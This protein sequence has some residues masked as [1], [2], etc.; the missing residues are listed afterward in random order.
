MSAVIRISSLMEQSGVAFGTSGARG[1]ETA[2]TDEVCYAYTAAFIQMLETRGEIPGENA[3]VALAGDLRPSTPRIMAAVARAVADRG[4]AVINCGRVPSPAVALHGL[5]QG[6]PS[7]MVTGSH[8]PQDRNGIKFNKTTGEILKPDEME[9]KA[10]QVILPD[11]FDGNGMFRSAWSPGPEQ[12]DAEEAY[13]NRWIKGFP[14]NCLKGLR[15]G[16][17]GHSAVG[18]ELLE[19]ITTELGAHVTRLG[20]SETFIAVDTEAIRPEDVDLALRW[21]REGSFDAIVSTDGDGDRPLISDENGK[22]IRGDV[23]GILC[24]SFLGADTVVT[25]VS[26]NTAVEKLGAFEEVRRT[27]I[28]SPYVIEGMMEAVTAGRNRV[29]GYE[30]NGGFLTASPIPID[31]GGVLDPLPTRD[32][33]VV[34]LGLLCL[35]RRKGISLSRLVAELPPRFTASDRLKDFPT[36]M[37]LQIVA[38][39][40]K[41]GAGA[42]ERA[43][44]G[45]GRVTSVNDLDGLRMT[46]E[47]GDIVHL[48][49]SGNAPELRC[50][51]EAE[52]EHRAWEIN[53]KAIGILDTWR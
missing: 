33:V 39:L 45:L 28:G 19:R 14:P 46:F 15:L 30:A 48:R 11:H 26:S 51:T 4:H 42:M 53:R 7:I 37:S 13:V 1:L 9:I 18:A 2:M 43:F 6:I 24:A 47:N 5:Q 35:S 49:P 21:A 25:P 38:N 31:Q 36:G 10:Q 17:Y 23:A 41:G 16:L 40:L 8:I 34:H 3:R 27:R 44:P 12:K 50:Y 32:P 20:F 22:W 52:S 29:V